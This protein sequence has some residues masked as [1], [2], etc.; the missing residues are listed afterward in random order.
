LNSVYAI[1][2][3]NVIAVGNGVI[4][5]T[6]DGGMN[7]SSKSVP[8]ALSDVSFCDEN[9][10]L[11]VGYY[12]I[13]K[14]INGGVDWFPLYSPHTGLKNVWLRDTNTITITMD[15]AF[16][17]SSN[18]GLNW[19]V[20]TPGGDYNEMGSLVYTNKG[21]KYGLISGNKVTY[22]PPGS[23]YFNKL[24]YR[25]GAN[26]NWNVTGYGDIYFVIRGSI[27]PEGKTFAI[28]SGESNELFGVNEWNSNDWAIRHYPPGY[29]L[30]LC[31]VN[32]SCGTAVTL[33]GVYET[34]NGGWNWTKVSENVYKSLSFADSVTAYAVGTG[35]K[36]G[37]R[38]VA[39]PVGV[40]DIKNINEFNL[41]QNYPN[42]FNPSTTIRYE[43]AE[44]SYV[45][46]AIYDILGKKILQPVNEL[47]KAGVYT[48]AF[49]G[50]SLSTG[51]YIYK[52]SSG[53]KTFIRKMMLMK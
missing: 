5:K 33:G 14:T 26:A 19:L 47:K 4:L 40:Q 31:F 1:D 50:S 23:F 9:N 17:R 15:S 13:L 20:I 8:G 7:W 18:G 29:V 51:V 32:D 35:G 46:L 25:Y 38:T 37:K 24:L 36:I 44:D 6:T 52:L 22:I 16:I 43:I 3:L 10:G 21:S 30:D 34:K 27:L 28:L 45:T 12:D 41:E 49:D 39:P 48:Y 42:P 11:A 53:S 2:S